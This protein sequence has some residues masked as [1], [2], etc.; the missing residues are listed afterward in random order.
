M[1][2][3]ACIWFAAQSGWQSALMAPT[4][5]LARQHFETLSPLMARLGLTCA[6]L[7]GS[8]RA[9]SGGRRWRDWPPVPSTCA[10]VPTPC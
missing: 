3:A 9:R 7:T 8:T 6:L 1:V 2:A 5:I 10:S 4:E